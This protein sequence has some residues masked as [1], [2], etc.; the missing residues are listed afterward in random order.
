MHPYAH[1]CHQ[2]YHLHG[3]THRWAAKCRGD[4]KSWLLWLASAPCASSSITIGVSRFSRARCR[5]DRRSKSRMLTEAPAGGDEKVPGELRRYR[6]GEEQT[7]HLEAFAEPLP[8]SPTCEGNAEVHR[9][10]REAVGQHQPTEPLLL[11]PAASSIVTTP[12]S[13]LSTAMCSAVLS[14]GMMASPCS[15]QLPCAYS[16]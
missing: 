10:C 12:T 5:A 11:L 14:S 4:T 15:A 13:P 3:C 2:R 8:S 7:V 6:E 1:L 9:R 16:L